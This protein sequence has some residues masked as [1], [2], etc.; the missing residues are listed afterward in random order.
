[1]QFTFKLEAIFMA[2]MIC[3]LLVLSVLAVVLVPKFLP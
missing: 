3:A 1:V 2:V